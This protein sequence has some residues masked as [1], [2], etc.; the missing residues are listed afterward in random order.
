MIR[1]RVLP[2]LSISIMSSLITI[3]VQASSDKS[4]LVPVKII[5]GS[6]S[7]KSVPTSNNGFVSAHNMMYRHSVTFYDAKSMKLQAT[8]SD[9]V[10]LSKFDFPKYADS[11]QGAPIE[12]AFLPV[13]L[14]VAWR[15]ALT[16]HHY[17][18]LI[19]EEARNLKLILRI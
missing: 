16:L 6:I 12:G 7:S 17:P 19:L 1:K 5:T 15:Q 9:I 3:P 11:F 10:K 13:D 14:R 18:Q 8:V 2:I 4:L